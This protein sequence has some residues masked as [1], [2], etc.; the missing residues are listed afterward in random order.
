MHSMV[1]V[2]VKVFLGLSLEPWFLYYAL[3]VK[4]LMFI[5]MLDSYTIIGYI[6]AL[7][8][9]VA[10]IMNQLGRWQINDFEYD[11]INFIGSLILTV[12][13]WQIGCYPLMSLFIVWSVFSAKNVLGDVL[14]QLFKKDKKK[15]I[16]KEN[17][18]EEPKKE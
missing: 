5:K 6:G 16:E 11:F 10:V 8:L 3:D 9:M 17:V 13:T 2:H 12:Y 18:K 7:V 4:D 1:E 15:E 14:K